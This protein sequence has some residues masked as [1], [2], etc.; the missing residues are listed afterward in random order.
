MKVT[1]LFFAFFGLLGWLA[2]KKK[3]IFFGDS[4]TQAAVKP[5]GYIEF[6]K[7]ELEKKGKSNDYEL[8]GAGISG[9]KVPD[10]LARL[11]KDVLSQS[12]D[13]V[14]IYI[15]I[16]DVWHYSHPCCKDNGGGTPKA[17]FESGLK[18][19]I[20]RIQAKGTSV[21]LCT[22]SVIGEAEAGTNAQD[23]M[24]DDYAAVSRKVAKETNA[25]LCDLRAAFQRY[26]TK[27]NKSN[28]DKNVLTTDGVHLNSTGNQ[29]VGREMLRFLP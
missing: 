23:K 8:I 4:I 19:I 14:F 10:L 27:Y 21:V 28:V 13:V 2:P 24:L 5:D 15:G 6:M 17:L 20:S 26:L 1:L 3:V 11:E 9:N 29:L 18:E 25:Q 22:P 16:N 12:P 7:K